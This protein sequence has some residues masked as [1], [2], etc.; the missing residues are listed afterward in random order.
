MCAKSATNIERAES[1]MGTFGSLTLQL[2]HRFSHE[3]GKRAKN[4]KNRCQN[5]I[6][7]ESVGWLKYTHSSMR[8]SEV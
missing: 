5:P 8:R 4:A 6:P 7:Q 1:F 3:F 2:Q